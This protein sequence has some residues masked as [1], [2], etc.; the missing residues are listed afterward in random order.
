M[1]EKTINFSERKAALASLCQKV[2]A[3]FA[4]E[5][6]PDEVSPLR[7]HI[8][9]IDNMAGGFP[10]NT[11]S[12]VI[13]SKPSCG[14]TF[15]IHRLLDQVR[16]ARG[17][18]ALVDGSDSFSPDSITNTKSLEHLYWVR[19]RDSQE[20]I[21]VSDLLAGDGNFSLLLI[22]LR[23]N[24]KEAIHSIPSNRWYR[25][26]R[27]VKKANSTCI[28]LTPFALLAA[29]K[30]RFHLVNSWNL[31]ALEQSQ[32]FLQEQLQIETLSESR[33]ERIG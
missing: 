1:N 7:T 17:Y 4:S 26:Q 12:E 28:A 8:P 14:G 32:T 29:A 25:L 6:D 11:L 10:K 18:V 16:Q 2:G 5:I 27:T 22:D 31:A 9:A 33:I 24:R 20:A 15:L 13:E 30:L 3:Y 19:C 23:L 21:R